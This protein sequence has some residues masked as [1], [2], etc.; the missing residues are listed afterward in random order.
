MELAAYLVAA[1]AA[2]YLYDYIHRKGCEQSREECQREEDREQI[3]KIKRKMGIDKYG[4]VFKENEKENEKDKLEVEVLDL[5][6]EK[7]T[8][9]DT[10]GIINAMRKCAVNNEDT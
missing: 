2:T 4:K 7:L 9:L 8:N 6:K 1:G 3:H 5:M 10:I